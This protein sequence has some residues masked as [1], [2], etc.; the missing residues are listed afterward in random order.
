MMEFLYF[1]E[2]KTE[3]IPAVISLI[4]FMIGAFITFYLIKKA[5]LKEEKRITELMESKEKKSLRE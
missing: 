4:I 2:D 1:P 5:S 3:Y